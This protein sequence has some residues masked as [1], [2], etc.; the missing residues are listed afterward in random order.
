ME[1]DKALPRQWYYVIF[2]PFLSQAGKIQIFM[3]RQCCILSVFWHQ[4]LNVRKQNTQLISFDV[5][6]GVIMMQFSGLW[7]FSGLEKVVIAQFSFLVV[8]LA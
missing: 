8:E 2:K 1:D 4:R 3:L 7:L 5:I 6:T